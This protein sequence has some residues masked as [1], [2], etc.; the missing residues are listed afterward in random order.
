MKKCKNNLPVLLDVA[1]R[2][3][4]HLGNPE[5]DIRI[6]IEIILFEAS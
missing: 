3:I 4:F 6:K 2:T 1:M 5:S